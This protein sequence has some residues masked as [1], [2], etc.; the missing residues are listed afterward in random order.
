MTDET[1]AAPIRYFSVLTPHG[2]EDVQAD[3]IQMS[4]GDLIFRHGGEFLCAFGRGY[5][6]KAEEH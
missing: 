2:W 1:T 6:L 5:W 4:G 3:S